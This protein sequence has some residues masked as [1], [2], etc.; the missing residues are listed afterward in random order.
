MPARGRKAQSATPSLRVTSS[1]TTVPSLVTS[2]VPLPVLTSAEA[3]S[4]SPKVRDGLS[5]AVTNS[6]V[7]SDL[8]VVKVICFCAA[9]V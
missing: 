4:Q 9:S 8:G 3:S 1:Q 6:V 2:T 7:L 5:S